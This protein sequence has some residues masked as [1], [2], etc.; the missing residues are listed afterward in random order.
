MTEVIDRRKS[1]LEQHAQTVTMFCILGLIGYGAVQITELTEYMIRLD[2]RSKTYTHNI[3]INAL[4][5]EKL[6]A[7]LEKYVPLSEFNITVERY[8]TNAQIINSGYEKRISSLERKV[9]TIRIK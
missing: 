4:S 8:K 1:T 2:E 3:E 9:E 5:V 7:K 6:E